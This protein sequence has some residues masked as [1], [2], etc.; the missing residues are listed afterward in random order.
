M[1]KKSSNFLKD[2]GLY[3]I[4][5]PFENIMSFT[6]LVGDANFLNGLELMKIKELVIEFI[7]IRDLFTTVMLSP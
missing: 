5:L 2:Y 7:F 6:K 3:A 4:F 1:L